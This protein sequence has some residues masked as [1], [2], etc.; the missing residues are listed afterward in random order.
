MMPPVVPGSDDAV[1]LLALEYGGRSP[2]WA[3]QSAPGTLVVPQRPKEAPAEFARRVVGRMSALVRKSKRLERLVLVVARSAEGSLAARSTIIQAALHA[4]SDRGEGN[5]VLSAEDTADDDLRREL[6]ALVGA[7]SAHLPV[8]PAL[9]IRFGEPLHGVR[10]C[11]A[12]RLGPE[13][14][15]ADDAGAAGHAQ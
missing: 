15:A 10:R 13:L 6:F 1:A 2:V 12:A 3:R 9:G 7:W 11:G 5:I 8:G 14:D 4:M